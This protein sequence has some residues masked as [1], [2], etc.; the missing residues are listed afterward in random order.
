MKVDFCRRVWNG[1]EEHSKVKKET[2]GCV[3]PEMNE[4]ERI[5]SDWNIR[6]EWRT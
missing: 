6:N 1:Q 4:P 2:F 5:N 3:Q